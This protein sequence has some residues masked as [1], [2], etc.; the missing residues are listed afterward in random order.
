M[1]ATI[2]RS[3]SSSAGASGSAGAATGAGAEAASAAKHLISHPLTLG[4]LATSPK[5]RP[6]TT[7][8]R[9]LSSGPWIP[10]KYSL[11]SSASFNCFKPSSVARLMLANLPTPMAAGGP[12]I[13]CSLAGVFW[14]IKDS[15]SSVGF[16]AGNNKTSLILFLFDRNMVRRSTPKPKPPVGGRP[17]SRELTNESSMTMASSSPAP[18]A[19]AW[20]KKSL[21]W[22][23]G[24]FNSV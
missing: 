9:S 21:Y 20:S 18:P 2:R 3:S 11:P 8:T 4:N 1:I 23:T 6:E 15:C 24:L 7:A 5:E 22:T 19:L 16:I 14:A 10:P 17:C 13:G 12:P